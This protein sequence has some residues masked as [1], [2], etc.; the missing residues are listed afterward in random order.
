MAQDNQKKGRGRKKAELP[1]LVDN[2]KDTYEV[3]KSNPLFSLWKSDL[4]LQEFKILD[5]YLAR[6]DS[7]K[8]EQRCVRFEKGEM[9]NL[10]GVVKINQKDLEERLKH[11][12]GYI[13]EIKDP[14]KKK[15]FALIVLFEKAL[16]EKDENEQWQIDLEC[17][18]SAME[19]FFNIDD[20][21]YLRYKLRNV[22]N[23]N[24][25]YSYILFMYIESNRYRKSWE[26]GLDELRTILNCDN[27]ELYNEYKRF[28][29]K[30]LKRCYEE[31]I[32]KTELRY[33]Y[34]AVKRGRKVVKVKF[35]I[36][37]LRDLI[38]DI[39][40]PIPKP[41]NFSIPEQIEQP[42]TESENDDIYYKQDLDFY[43][44]ACEE[45]FTY[46]EMNLI[47]EMVSQMPLPPHSMGNKFA[48]YHYLSQKYALLKLCNSKKPIKNKFA[49]FM[50][51]I[52]NDQKEQ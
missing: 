6:I 9:E 20:I 2:I 10:L 39:Q 35:T 31:L 38:S 37:T 41:K 28:N 27:N 46:E 52:V 12:M 19:Y 7:H 16:C 45:A 21:G 22:I 36:E 1:P 13:V 11:L 14:N 3:Q 15:G 50:T 17:T 29:D 25:R 51:M 43:S 33:T 4:T 26:V 8:P 18:Q 40:L 34:E 5:T 44:E 23:I 47:F 49:Y 48:V 32:K 30:V 42:Y 24:S